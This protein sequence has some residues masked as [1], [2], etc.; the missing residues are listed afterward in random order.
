MAS[1]S[2]KKVLSVPGEHFNVVL[3]V[4]VACAFV[5]L[6]ISTALMI[7]VFN[8]SEKQFLLKIEMEV[9]FSSVVLR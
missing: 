9:I 2:F 4:S 3:V 5:F 1:L 8:S 6:V 7:S